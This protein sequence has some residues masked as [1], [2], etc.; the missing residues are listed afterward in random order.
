MFA[1]VGYE[2]SDENRVSWRLLVCRTLDSRSLGDSLI[3]VEVV[4]V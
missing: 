4:S 3:G 1:E 2:L